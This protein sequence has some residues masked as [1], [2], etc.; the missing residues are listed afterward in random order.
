MERGMRG[1]RGAAT[2]VEGVR[3]MGKLAN[4]RRCGRPYMKIRDTLCP[5]CQQ[6]T[7]DD[8]IA[9]STYLRDNKR[10]DFGTVSRETGVPVGVIL[11]FVRTGKLNLAE[12]GV[13][14]RLNCPKCGREISAGRDCPKCGPAS[15]A[16]RSSA[17]KPPAGRQAPAPSAPAEGGP[18]GFF[19][20]KK[21]DGG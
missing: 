5:D 10:A 7:D 3:P 14:L 13:D 2:P 8:F 19:S 17:P 12:L 1:A 20:Y 4:C 18:S 16:P 15:S 11:G 9:V 6:K 21:K